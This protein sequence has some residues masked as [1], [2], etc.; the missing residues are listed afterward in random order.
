VR[1]P[2]PRGAGWQVRELA[3]GLDDWWHELEALFGLA[4]TL[5]CH[6]GDLQEAAPIE[7]QFQVLI[8]KH[9]EDAVAYARTW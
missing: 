7:Q 8:A 4:F 2:W 6:Q 1:T 5:A 3:K 9:L